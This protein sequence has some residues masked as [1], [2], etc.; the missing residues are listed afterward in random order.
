MFDLHN[1]YYCY[2]MLSIFEK[3][4]VEIQKSV[5]SDD[6]MHVFW[7][8]VNHVLPPLIHVGGAGAW[9]QVN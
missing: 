9:K 5:I 3:W 8:I 2:G 6:P 4:Y 1:L 7:A